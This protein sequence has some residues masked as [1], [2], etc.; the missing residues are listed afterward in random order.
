MWK[1]TAVPERPQ[2]TTQRMR[3]AC[4]IPKATKTHSEYVIIIIFRLP[5]WY[6]T[7]TLSILLLYVI[8]V[9]RRQGDEVQHIR[10]CGTKLSDQIY[11]PLSAQRN[12]RNPVCDIKLC[13]P[14]EYSRSGSVDKSLCTQ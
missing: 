2:M 12:L 6:V 8:N 10:H 4:L 11:I 9:Y 5:Q 1:N 3:I 14:Q 13:G 7:R